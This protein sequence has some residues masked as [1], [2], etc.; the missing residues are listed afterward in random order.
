MK[1]L[2]ETIKKYP[3]VFSIY[4]L[5][6][7]ICWFV[8]VKFEIALIIFLFAIVNTGLNDDIVTISALRNHKNK[9]DYI[10]NKEALS[11]IKIR[12]NNFNYILSVAMVLGINLH[13]YAHIMSII[14]PIFLFIALFFGSVLLEKIELFVIKEFKKYFWFILKWVDDVMNAHIKGILNTI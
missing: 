14:F 8:P 6:V 4:A 7:V 9:D 3:I 13:K 10:K 12:L 11:T 5:I 2:F 1:E